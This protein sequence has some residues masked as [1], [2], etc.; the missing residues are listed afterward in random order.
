MQPFRQ[1]SS[2]AALIYQ[3][4]HQEIA[5]QVTQVTQTADAPFTVDT[6]AAQ[7]RY[8]LPAGPDIDPVDK[9]P[10]SPNSPEWYIVLR[11]LPLLG[12][13][14]IRAALESEDDRTV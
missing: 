5:T 11:N 9:A 4:V 1:G 10:L 14:L 13:P 6:Q 8:L 2:C 12:H 7:I 3:T